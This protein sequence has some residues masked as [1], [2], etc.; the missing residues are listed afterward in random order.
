LDSFHRHQNNRCQLCFDYAGTITR[1]GVLPN[2]ETTDWQSQ[3]IERR[4][5]MGIDVAGYRIVRL[6]AKPTQS[7]FDFVPL[8]TV[9]WG[10]LVRV[11]AS[12]I[13]SH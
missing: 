6:L 2:H 5:R 3:S 11:R 10:F 7:T 1:R 13:S 9:I 8:F 12:R 4:T